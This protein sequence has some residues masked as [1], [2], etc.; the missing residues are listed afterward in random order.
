MQTFAISLAYCKLLHIALHREVIY[1]TLSCTGINCIGLLIDSIF[2]VNAMRNGIRFY[3]DTT[4]DRGSHYQDSGSDCGTELL[5][6]QIRAKVSKTESEMRSFV[7]AQ[8]MY[9]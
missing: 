9:F 5:N 2:G 7:T 4:A 3:T 8:E 1:V 6:A